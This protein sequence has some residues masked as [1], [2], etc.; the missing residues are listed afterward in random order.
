MN[1]K[2]TYKKLSQVGFMIVKGLKEELVTQKHNATHKL[3][4]SL[5]PRVKGKSGVMDIITSKL[6]WRAVNNPKAAAEP[7]FNQIKKWV[8]AKGLPESAVGGI[9]NKLKNMFYGKPYVYWTEG[10]NLKRTDFAG[11]TARKYKNKVATE[12]APA[13]GKDVVA[14]IRKEIKQNYKRAKTI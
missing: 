2:H 11:I 13:I 1:L 7:N 12:L 10:N 4:N 6:Y 14:M 3:S 9:F 8:A 5:K